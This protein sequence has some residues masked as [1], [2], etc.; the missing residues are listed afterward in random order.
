MRCVRVVLAAGLLATGAV[1]CASQ[2]TSTSSGFARPA[3]ARV[4]TQVSTTSCAQSSSSSSGGLSSGGV[5]SCTFVLS[6]G[7][8]FRC[9][10]AFGTRRPTPGVSVLEHAKAC[11][12]LTALV[13]SAPSRA[14]FVAIGKTRSCLTKQGL[15]VI[16][17]PV[18]PAQGPNSPEGELIVTK[19]TAPTFIAFY[20]SSRKARQL[21]PRVIQNAKH[22]GGQVVR[23][24]AV[25]VLWTRPPTSQ[26]R[27]SVETC[28]FG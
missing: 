5:G 14:V 13:I 11:T 4:V 3:S 24:G 20:T 26:L 2:S 8:R 12:R 28:A 17:G 19:A 22:L 27:N 21:E 23:R 10:L 1:G 6:D 9:P 16:G 25:T 7:R 18:L 15:R